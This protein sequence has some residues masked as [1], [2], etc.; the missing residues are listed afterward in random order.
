MA[1]TTANPY[2]FTKAPTTDTTGIISSNL[3]SPALATAQTDTTKYDPS[4]VTAKGVQQASTY[5]ASKAT[6]T[7]W[8]VNSNQTVAGQLDSILASNSPLLQRANTKAQESMNS[9]GL[10]NSS[11]AVGAGQAALYDA[12]LPIAQADAAVNANAGK[13]KADVANNMS[14]YNTTADNTSKQYNAGA[15]Q[16]ASKDNATAANALQSQL[17]QT[18]AQLDS[19]NT[20]AKN[21]SGLAQYDA[22][23]KVAMQNAD[24]AGKLQLQQLDA[25]T[26]T[27][28]E[29]I[30]AQYKNQ[31]QTNQ[32]LAQAQASMI[33]SMTKI[34]QDKDL[35]GPSK[36]NLIN[37]IGAVFKANM[38]SLAA[39][40]GLKLDVNFGYGDVGSGAISGSTVEGSG[41]TASPS[42]AGTSVNGSTTSSGAPVTKPAPTLPAADPIVAA[43]KA[44]QQALV[45]KT[46]AFQVS[47][48]MGQ[49]MQQLGLDGKIP[50]VSGNAS[51]GLLP[52]W[53]TSTSTTPLGS[54]GMGGGVVFTP[55][56]ADARRTSAASITVYQDGRISA[57]DK[58]DGK[59]YW[60]P[61]IQAVGGTGG[62]ADVSKWGSAEP[63][64]PTPVVS[65]S[66]LPPIT[67]RQGG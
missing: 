34:M 31:M 58:N 66:P 22:T 7:N 62:F 35:D 5:D 63:L 21:K 16:Q 25:Q 20:D 38:D 26:R 53:F 49:S 15:T 27:Q 55:T 3:N 36:A 17:L 67:K 29:Q 4:T 10:L 48:P 61:S 44:A 52:Q 33:D 56:A 60:A 64:A 47:I 59:V 54:D 11:M 6:G 12:A 41:A 45:D 39:V 40:G 32:S 18:S 28:I 19:A 42:N 8:D 37:Q 9:R 1:T 51:Y 24:A 13:Y 46:R 57:V 65:P 2:D 50:G 30:D 43:Q 14:Q 23:V